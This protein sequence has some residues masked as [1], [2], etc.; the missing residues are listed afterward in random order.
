MDITAH[1]AR[2]AKCSREERIQDIY[3]AWAHEGNWTGPAVIRG[4]MS[5]YLKL[6]A[7]VWTLSWAVFMND[8]MPSRDVAQIHAM[9]LLPHVLR[10][11]ELPYKHLA[12]LEDRIIRATPN[13]SKNALPIYPWNAKTE[14]D[15]TDWF[16]TRAELLATAPLDTAL[17]LLQY[18]CELG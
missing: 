9:A 2:M 1:M 16:M 6:P 4:L 12:V 15:G 5:T 8:N 18:R 14:A 13:A 3:V 7:A 17:G 11:T 10:A